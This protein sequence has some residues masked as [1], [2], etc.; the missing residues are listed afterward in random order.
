M[1]PKSISITSILLFIT[2]VLLPLI[3]MFGGTIINAGNIS[4][5]SYKTL[6]MDA[7]Q[8]GLLKNSLYLA[9]G[10][11]FLAIIIGVPLGFLIARTDIYFI[12][13]FKYLYL[14]PLLI[15][16]YM[17]AIVWISLLGQKGIAN[18]FCMTLFSLQEPI[19]T[20]YGINGSIWVLALSYFPLITLLTIT[21]LSSMDHK[22]E[23]AGRLTRTEIGVLRGITFPLMIPYI[24][25]GAIFV[26]IF[27]LSNYGVPSLLRVNT[28]P[29]EIFA[30]FSAYYD[31][32]SATVLSLPI[33]VITILL[34][35]WQRK[36]MKEKS[37][38][39]LENSSTRART[40]SMGKGKGIIS[41]YPFIIIFLS[42]ITPLF[43][44]LI[45]SGSLTAYVKAFQTASSQIIGSFILAFTAA[46]LM[47]I[48]GFF[49]A[50]VIERTKIRGRAFIDILTFI[51]FAV[52]ATVLGIGL[53]KVWNR[54]AVEIIYGSSLII[55]FGYVSRFIPFVVRAISANLKQMNKN[56]E[57]AALLA[58]VGWLKRVFKISLPL[59]APGLL[60]GWAI[61]FVFCMGE[62]GTTLLV[63]PPGEATLPIRIYT[64]MHYGANQLVSALGVILIAI[65]IIPVLMIKMV[66]DRLG[67]QRFR[68]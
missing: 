54:P 57:E 25:S 36:F 7:R 9:V 68:V 48:L 39:T 24:L 4:I 15:P 65:T 49:I 22:L 19:F 27:A 34:I 26:F 29:I 12:K 60:A 16:P 50:Y 6:F 55:I 47:V 67:V 62:L 23:E 53:I 37:Y 46:T 14:A 61:A 13:Y 11:S 56:L 66:G 18:Q 5:E 52:P 59:L 1:H 8:L 21:G 17:N 31:N 38:V 40:I 3:F 42:V 30:Q 58:D 43:V 41:V 2:I 63:I 20:I 35:L 10:T 28:Y 44:L 45:N 32:N 64:L 51:P 33:V